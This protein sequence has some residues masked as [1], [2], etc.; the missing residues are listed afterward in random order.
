MDLFQIF[1]LPYSVQAGV[2]FAA[3]WG[4]LY[5]LQSDVRASK[6]RR[7]VTNASFAVFFAYWFTFSLGVPMGQFSPLFN[8]FG[9]GDE[10]T[11]LL[12]MLLVY[13]S[14]KGLEHTA[15]WK[16]AFSRSFDLTFTKDGPKLERFA[17]LAECSAREEG[18][19][20]IP[21]GDKFD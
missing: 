12:L 6:Y 2:T 13:S 10:I 16:A 15:Y 1:D 7:L 20:Y 14:F 21:P 11:F 8:V 9:I 4:L 3:S 17:S 19:P 5:L 18:T